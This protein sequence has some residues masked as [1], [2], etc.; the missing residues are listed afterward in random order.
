MPLGKTLEELSK[1]T[2]KASVYCAYQTLY[3]SLSIEDKK[4]LDA[5]W[6]INLP[7]SLI[8]KALRQEGH[9]TSNDSV[10]THAKGQCKCPK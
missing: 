3:N 6:K 4:A 10:R 9:K 7:V 1:N 8:V 2:K 5:A